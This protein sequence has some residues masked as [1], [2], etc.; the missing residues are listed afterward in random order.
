MTQFI[1]RK[2]DLIDAAY[3]AVASA[4]VLPEAEC[5]ES[6]ASAGMGAIASLFLFVTALTPGM[7][8][9]HRSAQTSFRVHPTRSVFHA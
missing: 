5:W 8:S 2:L 7:N 4:A 6:N 3:V 9:S 1:D